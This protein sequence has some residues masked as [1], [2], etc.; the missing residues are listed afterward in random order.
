MAEN[1][2]AS[3]RNT[4]YKMH[5]EKILLDREKAR[6]PET[7]ADAERYVNAKKQL[8]LLTAE[9]EALNKQIWDCPESTTYCKLRS[10]QW[11]KDR[12][13]KA[14]KITQAEYNVFLE[15]LNH[16]TNLYNINSRPLTAKIYANQ[17]L[18]TNYQ[19]LEYRY[20]AV[21]RYGVAVPPTKEVER[22]FIHKCPAPSCE[23]F[24]NKEWS[25]GICAVLVCKSCHETVGGAG[26]K[27]DPTTVESVKAIA[28]EAKPCPKCAA[29]IS[30]I[31][32]CDQ[33][34]C[35]QCKTAFS[36]KTGQIETTVVHNPHYYQWM[37]ESGQVIPRAGNIVPNVGD[38]NV[39]R[40]QQW[41]AA[42]HQAIPKADG[43]ALRKHHLIESAVR[44]IDHIRY[45]FLDPFTVGYRDSEAWRRKL[46]VQRLANEVND[47]AMKV[48]L[49]R[50]E[51]AANKQQSWTQLRDM[52]VAAA[53]DILG[54][55][56]DGTA[57]D[58]VMMQYESLRTFTNSEAKKVAKIY[59]CVCAWV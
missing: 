50:A 54:Q 58:E 44:N 13:L 42:R 24:L 37:R 57:E 11:E 53:R 41:L 10:E 14:K 30:K 8:K 9:N 35:T 56:L 34:W 7:M 26:H 46:R 43:E 40:L 1:L 38:C 36:W 6:F 47:T 27:C 39:M 18:I 45:T 48:E 4:K 59:N 29:A 19:N 33:M 23:G 49:Q 20:G 28:K 12:L 32:G 3:F 31:D 17:Q 22:V 5:R 52:F 21:D 15:T 55:L 51:K 2:T 16:A 25:C